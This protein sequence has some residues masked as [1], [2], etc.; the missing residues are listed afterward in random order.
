MNVRC[1]TIIYIHRLMVLILRKKTFEPFLLHTYVYTYTD[2]TIQTYV[3]W[4]G[5]EY[6]T[7]KSFFPLLFKFLKMS[8]FHQ[9]VRYNLITEGILDM[10]TN[11]KMYTK[12]S[13]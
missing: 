11:Q 7:K 10:H 13:D 5:M 3:F 12:A 1:R 6:D 4:I 8:K 9:N 2:V